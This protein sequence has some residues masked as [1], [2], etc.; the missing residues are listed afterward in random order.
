MHAFFHLLLNSCKKEGKIKKKIKE[1]QTCLSF[2]FRNIFIYKLHK[3][4]ECIKSWN[5]MLHKNVAALFI[6]DV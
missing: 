2:V 3:D 4:T 1:H 6:Y 5:K